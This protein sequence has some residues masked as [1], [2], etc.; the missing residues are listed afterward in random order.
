MLDDLLGPLCDELHAG[1]GDPGGLL[2]LPIGME[3]GNQG[4]LL[5]QPVVGQVEAIS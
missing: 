1:D 4:A 3:P 5:K 2:F